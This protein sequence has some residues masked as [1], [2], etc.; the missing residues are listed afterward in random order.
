MGCKGFGGGS[1][2]NSSISPQLNSK[3]G[4]SMLLGED[5]YVNRKRLLTY[6]IIIIII[7]GSTALRGPWP[8][9]AS[10]S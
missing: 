5:F 8:S 3:N 2:P 9:E 4:E 10:A 7:I 1:S 6:I